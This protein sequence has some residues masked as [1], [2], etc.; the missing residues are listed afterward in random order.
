MLDGRDLSVFGFC[1][2]IHPSFLL[3]LLTFCGKLQMKAGKAPGEGW[4]PGSYFVVGFCILGSSLPE[5]EAIEHLTYGR[6]CVH[7]CEISSKELHFRHYNMGIKRNCFG[8]THFDLI[9]TSL[10]R[11]LECI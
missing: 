11:K 10:H 3:I 7:V 9:T 1:L 5:G 4:D 2:L 6:E 8:I